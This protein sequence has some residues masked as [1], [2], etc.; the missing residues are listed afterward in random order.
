MR[1]KIAYLVKDGKTNQVLF[2]TYRHAIAVQKV[3]ALD[4]YCPD[5]NH[6]IIEC[7]YDEEY[8]EGIWFNY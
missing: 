8:T 4:R 2:M 7:V 6:Y 1:E 3:M 5:R